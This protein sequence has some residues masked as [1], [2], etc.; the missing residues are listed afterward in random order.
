MGVTDENG[1]GPAAT[2]NNPE[3]K[4]VDWIWWKMVYLI[5]LG[6]APFLSANRVLQFCALVTYWLIDDCFFPPVKQTS[7]WFLNYWISSFQLCALVPQWTTQQPKLRSITKL[8]VIWV[9]WI[10][11]PRTGQDGALLLR[12]QAVGWWNLAFFHWCLFTICCSVLQELLQLEDRLGSVSRGA[13]QN[14]IERFTFPHK[15]KKVRALK[16]WH[17]CQPMLVGQVLCAWSGRKVGHWWVAILTVDKP[18]SPAKIYPKKED[19]S[20]VL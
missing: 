20:L 10:F 1:T 13:V 6:L 16:S 7:P 3:A 15:Y 18:A 19:F 11:P 5:Y 4:A 17:G 12:R 8:L 2:N 9:Q 14:T